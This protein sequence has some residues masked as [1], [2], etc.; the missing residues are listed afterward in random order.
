MD[1]KLLH[2]LPEKNV[3]DIPGDFSYFA[4]E[5]GFPE[6]E[7]TARPFLLTTI[8]V[9]AMVGGGLATLIFWGSAVVYPGSEFA[10]RA[11]LEI[12]VIHSMSLIPAGMLAPLLAITGFGLLMGKKWGIYLYTFLLGMSVS[13]AIYC[14][15]KFPGYSIILMKT[16]KNINWFIY[17]VQ[18]GRL[19]VDFM[20]YFYLMT[21]MARKYFDLSQR[22]TLKIFA[23]G[24]IIAFMIGG[25]ITFFSA[26]LFGWNSIVLGYKN[27]RWFR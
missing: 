27:T 17:Q 20:I 26:S 16:G 19:L 10:N 18:Y 24:F 14:L 25:L 8:A 2:S 9:L 3:D 6:E 1:V 12:N 13:T 4:Q 22:E 11:I 15:I 7:T 5:N 21:A 23:I